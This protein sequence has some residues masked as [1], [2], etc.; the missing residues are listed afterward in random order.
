[1]AGAATASKSQRK[2]RRTRR[3]LCGAAHAFNG[4]SAATDFVRSSVVAA[5]TAQTRDKKSSEKRRKTLKGQTIARQTPTGA[6]RFCK[7]RSSIHDPSRL[8]SYE[9]ESQNETGTLLLIRDAVLQH[10]TRSGMRE[11]ACQ[12]KRRG[13][14]SNLGP[15]DK[16]KI[17]CQK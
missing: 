11:E 4:C 15:A 5:Q 16:I 17:N 8:L 7:H 1:M 12:R 13:G 9:G 3:P 6:K 2:P 14:V 10:V